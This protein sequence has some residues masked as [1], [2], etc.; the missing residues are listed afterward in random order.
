M[1]SAEVYMSEP[2][3]LIVDDE[4]AA[5]YGMRRALKNYAVTEAASVEAARQQVAAARPD[6]LLL[7]IRHERAGLP[8]RTG[9]SA[10]CTARRDANRA[11]QRTHRRRSHQGRRL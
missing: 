6:L 10:R 8:A 11:R 1:P 9:R 7:D 2:K 5:R 3:I 4:E